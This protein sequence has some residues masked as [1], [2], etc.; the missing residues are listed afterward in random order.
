ME[1]TRPKP[2]FVVEAPGRG[3]QLV[4]E[5]KNTVAPSPEW[6]SRFL[7]NLFLHAAI[8][9]SEYFLL[10]LRDHLY[11]W[12]RPD[13]ESQAPPD[14]EGDTASILAPYLHYIPGRLDTITERGFELLIYAWLA[15]LVTGA[16]P[17]PEAVRWIKGSGLLESIR[18]G[19]VRSQLAA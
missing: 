6:L 18:N 5:A 12:R 13:P 9:P 10:A 7:R 15:D 14:F 17:P 1:E 8:P 3:V 16:E 4:V 11:L 2:D 19:T